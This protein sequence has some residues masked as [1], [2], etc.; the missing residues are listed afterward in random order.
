MSVQLRGLPESFLTHGTLERA[1]LTVHHVLVTTTMGRRGELARTETT[2]ATG[3]V[4]A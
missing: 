1:D 4:A 3:F 2:R